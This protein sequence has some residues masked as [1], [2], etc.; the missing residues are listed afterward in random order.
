MSMKPVNTDPQAIEDV[1]TRGVVDCVLVEHL[2]QRMMSGERLRIKFGI[3]PTSP[4][5]HLGHTVPLMKLR[6]FQTLGHQAVLIIGDATAAIGD[7]TGRSESRKQLSKEEVEQNKTTYINQAAKVLDIEDVEIHHNGEWFFPMSAAEF[8]GLTS[9]VTVQQILQRE[10]FRK[11]VEDTDHPLTAIELTY[12][13]MQGYDSVRVVADVEIGGHDQLLNLMMGRRMQRHFKQEEQD[14][15]TVPLLEGTDG[16]RKM[17]KSFGNAVAL[18]AQPN[19]MF[20][21]LMTIPD[22]LIVKY[23]SLLT[24]L[25]STEIKA[26]EDRLAAGENPRGIKASLAWELVRMYNDS[27]IANSAKAAFDEQF[28][29]GALPENIQEFVLSRSMTIVEVLM[30]TGL[31]SSKSEARRLVEQGGVKLGESVAS[32]IGQAVSPSDCPLVLQ[33]GKRHFVRLVV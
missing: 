2:R 26:H 9:L 12:P 27:S 19:D 13:I 30:D 21:Q 7:P 4:N 17:S 23:F 11:R 1:L 20:G 3:D 22:G 29:E 24:D 5:M 31:V 28:T 8:L 16:V 6:Q 15:L 32:D 25:S 33:K 10:D 18:T 14:I